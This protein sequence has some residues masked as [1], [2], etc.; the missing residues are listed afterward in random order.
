MKL[1][2][3]LIAFL[4]LDLF[5][6]AAA[7]TNPIRNPG[8]ADPFITKSGDGYYYLLTTEWDSVR[9]SRATTIEGLKTASTKVIYQ[10]SA[11]D[12]CCN[13]W[14]PEIQWLGDRWYL[15][16]TAGGSANL[17]NQR[18]HVAR[19]GASAW[20]DAY[21]YVGTMS[22]QWSIDGSVM[23]FNAPWGNHFVYSCFNGQQY[24][25]ICIQKL[26][27]NNVAL[28]G[29]VSIISTPTASWERQQ[30]PVNE[31]PAA[32]YM[33]GRSYLAFSASYCWSSAYCLGLLTWSG[34]NPVQ[35]SSWAKSGG[36]VFSSA[37]GHYGTGHNSF[38]Q[39]IADG[40]WYNV[41]HATANANGACD[42]N[43]Y[44]MV[45]PVTANSNGSP[46]FGI[47]A[48]FSYGFAEPS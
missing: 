14:A 43:R 1:F 3:Y 33:G 39:G 11:T 38:F 28:T 12:R 17:D 34:G 32:F 24:Q 4:T 36:C 2:G 41:F 8:G 21:T 23:R 5:S 10:S 18:L 31:G 48:P 30:H 9:I 27:D 16:F 22:N 15:Y 42:D 47:P 40:Q 26:A 25:S 6:F 35:A 46:N 13:V 45:Q 44:T 29:P 37:N 19:G 20:D 7:Y